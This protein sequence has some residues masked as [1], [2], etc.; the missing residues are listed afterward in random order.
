MLPQALKSCPK[1]NKSPD[2]VTLL[3][4]HDRTSPNLQWGGPATTYKCLH[5]FAMQQQLLSIA[6]LEQNRSEVSMS[7]WL[8]LGTCATTPL[9]TLQHVLHQ[10]HSNI[11]GNPPISK[12]LSI[13]T[14]F[15]QEEKTLMLFALGQSYTHF[16]I[17]VTRLGDL[18][19]FWP[20]FKAFGN[21]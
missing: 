3:L 16:T 14:S 15:S 17:S 12:F 7:L 5:F 6:R 10:L 18:L 8:W 11:V 4:R 2:L 1:C 19:D 21:N 13:N 20:L 9:S